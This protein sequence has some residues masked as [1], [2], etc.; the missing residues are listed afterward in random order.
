MIGIQLF[1]MRSR[2]TDGPVPTLGIL[3]IPPR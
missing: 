3:V 1:T 2:Y